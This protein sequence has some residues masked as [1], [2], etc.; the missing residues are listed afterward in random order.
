MRCSRSAL[1]SAA[2]PGAPA[3]RRHAAI[4]VGVATLLGCTVT[5]AAD[6][7]DTESA[8]AVVAGPVAPEAAPPATTW[9]RETEAA[10]T[11]SARQ[12]DRERGPS[13]TKERKRNAKERKAGAT[14][15]TE[16]AVP[17]QAAALPSLAE[18]KCSPSRITGTHIWRIVCISPAQQQANDRY[19]EQLAK[20][21]LRRLSEVGSLAPSIPSR[22]MQGG[23]P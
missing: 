23:I 16:S 1:G 19:D 2:T 4:V 10:A 11:T 3:L 22:Y 5:V 17:L 12:T 6:G 9:P 20:D 14:A 8:A 21:Y 7:P 13:D 18:Q 15:E